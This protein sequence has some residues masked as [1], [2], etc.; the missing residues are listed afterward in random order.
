MLFTISTWVSWV[1]CQVL[2]TEAVSLAS[3]KLSA[4]ILQI[5]LVILSDMIYCISG[6]NID[7]FIAA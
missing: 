2:K 1:K 6:I 5:S 7:F 3:S 4:E